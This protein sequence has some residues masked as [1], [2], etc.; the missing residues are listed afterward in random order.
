MG[1][2][3]SYSKRIK[4]EDKILC[5]YPQ[6][7]AN[8]LEITQKKYDDDDNNNHCNCKRCVIITKYENKSTSFHK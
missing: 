2:K 3:E 1:K 6:N 5:K 4:P 7:N 8:K